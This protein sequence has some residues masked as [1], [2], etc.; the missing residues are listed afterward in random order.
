M[1]LKSL[2]LISIQRWVYIDLSVSRFL[3]NLVEN[4]DW[5]LVWAMC[6]LDLKKLIFSNVNV[7]YPYI[8]TTMF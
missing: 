4:S 8:S 3:L 2:V 5:I 6:I 7:K 1:N